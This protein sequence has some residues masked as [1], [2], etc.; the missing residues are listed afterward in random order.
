MRDVKLLHPRLQSIIEQLKLACEKE[1]LPLLI[2]ETLRTVQEQDDLYAQGRTKPG[3][4]VTN[5]T[6]KSMLSQH[7]W[8]IAFDFCRNIKGKEYD[9]K[10][11]FFEKVAALGKKLGLGWGGDW[12]SFVDKPHLYLPDW[13]KTPATLKEKYG[14]LEKF[15]KTWSSYNPNTGGVSIVPIK[16][17]QLAAI[18]D[19]YTFPKYGADGYWGDETKAVAK[20]AIVKK[21]SPMKYQELAIIVQSAVG[22]DM[23]GWCGDKTKSAIQKFQKANGLVADGVVGIK[24]WMKLMGVTDVTVKQTDI[25]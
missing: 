25:D 8:G 2:T 21:F 9:D 11:K 19:G 12:I 4:I 6:G 18:A 13:G 10:D 15:K 3:N 20:K 5:A 17:F 16:D 23:D 22:T 14:T 24:T 7:Q 1:G